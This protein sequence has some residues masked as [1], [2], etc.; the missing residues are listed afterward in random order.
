MR[1]MITA[2]KRDSGIPSDTSGFELYCDTIIQYNTV[3]KTFGVKGIPISPIGDRTILKNV[4]MDAVTVEWYDEDMEVI[5]TSKPSAINI[6][7]GDAGDILVTLSGP[8][9][10][11]GAKSVKLTFPP[12]SSRTY[13]ESSPIDLIVI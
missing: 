5:S 9:V 7:W 4:S 10:P 12:G 6:K 13:V 2:L 8:P 3:A 11:A 1:R